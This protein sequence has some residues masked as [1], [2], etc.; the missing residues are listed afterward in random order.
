M[1]HEAGIYECLWRPNEHGYETAGDVAPVLSKG[2]ADMEQDPERFK[3]L[4]AENG[5]GTY[6]QWMPI[7][8]EMVKVIKRHPKAKIRAWG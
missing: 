3:A 8:Q 6:E 1:A 2:I 5:W 7:L 4:D